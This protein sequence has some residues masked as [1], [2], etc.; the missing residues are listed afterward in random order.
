MPNRCIL[1]GM[2]SLLIRERKINTTIRY[3]CTLTMMTKMQDRQCGCLQ[4][5]ADHVGSVR[6]DLTN[7]TLKE[8]RQTPALHALRVRSYPVP[9][10]DSGE[11]IGKNM[12]G[13]SGMVVL[14]QEAS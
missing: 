3:L 1:G 2:T 9:K 13:A 10:P 11:C 12:M 4:G 6:M 8:G 5:W 7:T 14:V